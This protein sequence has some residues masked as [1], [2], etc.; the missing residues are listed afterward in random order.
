MAS[1]GFCMF[2]MEREEDKMRVLRDSVNMGKL[3][4]LLK[5]KFY[6]I[7]ILILNEDSVS[8]KLNTFKSGKKLSWNINRFEE[9]KEKKV[10]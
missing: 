7:K 9:M 10:E 1:S 5:I 6:M 2:F 8:V 3:F 4:F